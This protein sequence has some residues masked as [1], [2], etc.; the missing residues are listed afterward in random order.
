MNREALF[1]D[2]TED[3]RIGEPEE[4]EEVCLRFRT[5]KGWADR[6]FFI[7]LIK[8]IQVRM[9]RRSSDS[10]FDYYEYRMTLGEEPEVFTFRR[11]RTAGN[12]AATTVWERWT[13]PAG[14]TRFGSRRD[15]TRR[16]GPKAR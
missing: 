14:I 10:L 12:S 11:R 6:V 9:N 7:R 5:L 8:G 13:A 2:E 1:A 4:G 15:F 3:Y 16:S